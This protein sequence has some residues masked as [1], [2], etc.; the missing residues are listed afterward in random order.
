MAKKPRDEQNIKSLS[1][2]R[3]SVTDPS[4]FA[5]GPSET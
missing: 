3:I 2:V 5:S 1:E 4:P